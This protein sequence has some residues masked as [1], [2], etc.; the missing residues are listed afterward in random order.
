MSDSSLSRQPARV[1]E[2][3]VQGG[4]S[5]RTLALLLVV[6]AA[7]LLLVFSVY[8]SCRPG[9]TAL[10]HL[11]GGGVKQAA[12]WDNYR[13][14]PSVDARCL[15]RSVW[16]TVANIV[17][18][19]L[20]DWSSRWCSISACAVSLRGLSLFPHGAGGFRGDGVPVHVQRHH[21]IA[22][23][24]MQK[25]PAGESAALPRRSRS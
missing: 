14:V 3:P 2:A 4:I 8:R 10:S 15:H 11:P 13:C 19:A 7:I 25:M 18:Q 23:Y 22:S 17:I 16:W 1:T 21:R 12:G 5:D 24:L 6:P 9:S 20:G